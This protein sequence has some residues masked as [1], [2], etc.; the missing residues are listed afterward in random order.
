ML[1]SLIFEMI[2]NLYRFPNQIYFYKEIL[3]IDL[4]V[5]RELKDQNRE[6]SNKKF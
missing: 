6:K 5:I 3:I 4:N 2:M 1:E